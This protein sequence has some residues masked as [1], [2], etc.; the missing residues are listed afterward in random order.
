MRIWQ[1]LDRSPQPLEAVASKKLADAV[2]QRAETGWK[3]F[4]HLIT[5]LAQPEKIHSPGVQIEAVLE[6]GYVEYL[7]ANF[8]NA[9]ARL[10]DLRQL[11]N[12]AA[13]YESTEAFLSDVALIGVERFSARD[14]IY[15]EDVLAGGDPDEY[16]VLSSIHQAKGL[17]WRVVFLIWTV[18][19]RFPTA[20]ALRDE[21]ALEEERRL[22]YVALTRAKDE[23]YLCYPLLGRERNR[24]IIMSPSPFVQEVNAS[25]MDEWTITVEE[26]D[27]HA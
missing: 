16:L 1:Q 12:F 9:D 27:D 24:S 3:E 26:A 14:G 15:G 13:R 4:A 20:R 17:E 23:L 21:E 22:F 7:R 6:S 18:S 25:L 19:G 11:A 8:T 10:E 5:G 2:P